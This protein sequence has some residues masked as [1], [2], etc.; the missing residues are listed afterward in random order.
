[1]KTILGQVG[2]PS[3]W[4]GSEPTLRLIPLRIESLG[5]TI[6]PINLHPSSSSI[7]P[8]KYGAY[9]SYSLAGVKISVKLSSFPFPVNFIGFSSLELHLIHVGLVG[10]IMCPFLQL[11]DQ[12]GKRQIQ[13]PQ[14]GLTHAMGGAGVNVVSH[15]FRRH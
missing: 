14:I 6:L 7:K 10:I 5:A 2:H 4:E 12:A 15:I 9:F 3:F 13:S 8:R 1:V 11:T